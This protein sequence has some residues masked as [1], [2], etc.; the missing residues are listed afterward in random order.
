MMLRLRLMDYTVDD[1]EYCI[2]VTSDIKMLLQAAASYILESK[3][4]CSE[5][6]VQQWDPSHDE[7]LLITDIT[8][9]LSRQIDDIRKKYIDL[10]KME[11]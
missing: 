6:S 9:D 11:G 8:L 2:I 3:N 1:Q 7:W 4:M 5:L 10:Q